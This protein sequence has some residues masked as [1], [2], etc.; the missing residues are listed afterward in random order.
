MLDRLKQGISLVDWRNLFKRSFGTCPH[1][2]FDSLP[3]IPRQGEVR[4]TNLEFA[5]VEEGSYM[6]KSRIAVERAR[7]GL[8][9]RPVDGG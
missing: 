6:L 9:C 3:E 8:N 4:G 2:G 7:N 1:R 5:M